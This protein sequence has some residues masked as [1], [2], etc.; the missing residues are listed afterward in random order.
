[1]VT[2]P[3]QYRGYGYVHRGRG[4]IRRDDFRLWLRRLCNIVFVVTYFRFV[5]TTSTT[6]SVCGNVLFVRGYCSSVSVTALCFDCGYYVF[7]YGHVLFDCGFV[8]QGRGYVR[9]DA[10]GLWSLTLR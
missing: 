2:T 3:L 9:P 4:Y 1:M 7:E 5:V 8:L 10:L 6:S